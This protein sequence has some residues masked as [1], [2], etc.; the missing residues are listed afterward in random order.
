MSKKKNTDPVIIG[1]SAAAMD[2]VTERARQQKEQPPEGAKDH[3]LLYGEAYTPRFDDDTNDDGELARAA[4]V[5]AY[6]ATYSDYSRK[7]MLQQAHAGRTTRIFEMW[8][9]SWDFD[10]YKPTTPRRDLVKAG[11]LILAEIERLDR[12]QAKA[13]QKMWDD[14]AAANRLD[15][16]YGDAK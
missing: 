13:E 8:P 5:Y 10:H 7:S 15:A 14:G 11:A 3:P 16:E 4:A 2:V 6:G 1:L 12:A 9:P